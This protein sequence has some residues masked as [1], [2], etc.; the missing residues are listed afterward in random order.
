MRILILNGPNL[1]LL[2]KREPDIYGNITLGELEARLI[3]FAKE[4]GADAVCIQSNSEGALIDAIQAAENEY[5]AVI[6]NA[7]AYTHYSIAIRDAIAA[8]DVPV[9]EVHISNI[10]AREAFRHASVIAPV[11]VGS[12][13]GFGP[14]GYFM[15]IWQLMQ[16]NL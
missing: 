9:V 12:I 4:R 16:S 7:G 6:L 13:S 1:N 10:Y 3:A 14:D 15:A 8:V 11:C 2:G 5:S